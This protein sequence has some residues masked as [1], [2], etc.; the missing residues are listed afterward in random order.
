MIKRKRIQREASNHDLNIEFDFSKFAKLENLQISD[1][2]GEI[3]TLIDRNINLKKT[4][5]TNEIFSL[6]SK[7]ACYFKFLIKV[8]KNIYFFG[9]SKTRN[10]STSIWSKRSTK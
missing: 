6:C 2:K 8:G 5:Y 3:K 9:P 1:I 10:F 7:K 4:K